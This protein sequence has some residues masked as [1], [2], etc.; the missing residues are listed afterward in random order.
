LHRHN[1]VGVPANIARTGYTGEDG[2]ETYILA[3]A[4]ERVWEAILKAGAEPSS[5]LAAPPPPPISRLPKMILGSLL[6]QRNFGHP[7]SQSQRI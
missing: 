6:F 3:A 2:F 4:A 1:G 7:G 5:R